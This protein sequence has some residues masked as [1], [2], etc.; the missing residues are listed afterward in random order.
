MSRATP[1][2]MLCAGALA[3]LPAGAQAADTCVQRPGRHF[4][5]GIAYHLSKAGVPHRLTPEKGV[6]VAEE[7]APAIDSATK[8]VEQHYWEVAL[9]LRD[10][11]EERT[12]VEWATKENLRFEVGDVVDLERKPAGRMFHLRSFTPEEV[13]LNRRKL[14]EAP[15]A[16]AC[17]LENMTALSWALSEGPPCSFPPS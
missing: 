11:C 14:D 12:L 7:L 16:P 13:A 17:R 10:A 5:A 1:F 2:A 4:D 3:G 8:Q 6:C 9:K 15:R